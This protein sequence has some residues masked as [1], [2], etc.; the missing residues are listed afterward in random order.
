LEDIVFPPLCGGCGRRGA[1]LCVRCRAELRSLP[2]PNCRRCGRV[3]ERPVATCPA[4][5]RWPVWIGSIR[6]AYLFDGPLR[7]SIHRFKYRG[8][9]ARG[10]SLA[11]LMLETVVDQ[12]VDADLVAFVAL[13]PRRRRERG[14]DQAEILARRVADRLEHPLARDLARVVDTPSQVGRTAAERRA[15]VQGAFA[16]NGESIT[17]ARIVLIDDVVTTG[18]TM[19]AASAALR[20][21]GADRIDGLSLAQQRLAP[22]GGTV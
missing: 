15:N 1:W 17:G 14:F 18:A 6:G 13:H 21:A 4:C 16:W 5:A 8:E 7:A 20:S 19:L 12:P 3:A 22:E 11:D 10:S 2:E 9:F